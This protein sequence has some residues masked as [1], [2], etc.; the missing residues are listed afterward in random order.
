MNQL[1]YY[2]SNGAQP[3]KPRVCKDCAAEGLPLTRP[4]TTGSG[5]LIPGPRCIT[6][7][8]IERAR[9][10]LAAHAKR[11][12]SVYGIT[13]AEYWAIYEAQGGKCY[14]CHRATGKTKRLAVDH[15]HT[16]GCGHDPKVG[17][18]KCVRA[19]V[20]GPCNR[21]VLGRL[22]IMGM[23]RCIEV[24]KDHPAQAILKGLENGT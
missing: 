6:H 20:C 18:R 7:D 8:R 16:M 17:C 15:D 3:M 23:I 19:L 4:T 24:L 5:V 2:L 14:T 12:E 9:R 22:D 11:V 21:E 10:R 13:G 1:N